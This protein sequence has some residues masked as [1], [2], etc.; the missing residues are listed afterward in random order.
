MALEE[1]AAVEAASASA[2]IRGDGAEAAGR[3]VFSRRRGRRVVVYRRGLRPGRIQQRP[4]RNP[5]VL[6]TRAHNH[7]L[8]RSH[9]HLS[10]IIHS[11][12]RHSCPSS[13]FSTFPFPWEKK[14]ERKKKKQPFF[15]FFASTPLIYFLSIFCVV[16]SSALVPTTHLLLGGLGECADF[17]TPP[18]SPP[19]HRT[20]N[21]LEEKKPGFWEP[22]PP[23]PCSSN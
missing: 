14:K 4:N 10:P 2:G 3:G 17:C 13:V 20:S 5:W 19:P 11:V 9:E 1:R 7:R 22:R 8:W 18:T 15:F 16:L 6:R 21:Q 23:L 12:N